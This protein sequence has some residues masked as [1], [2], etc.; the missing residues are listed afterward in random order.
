[1][2]ILK[3]ATDWAKDEVFSSRFFILFGILF[4]VSAIGFWQ[5]GRTDLAKAYQFP[6]LIAGLLILTVGLGIYFT[7]KSRV[8]SFEMAYKADPAAFVQSEI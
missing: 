6:T 5:L 7:N 1:M 4:L 2:E 3:L 8:T